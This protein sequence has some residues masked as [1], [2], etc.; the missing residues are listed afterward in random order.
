MLVIYDHH[1][2]LIVLVTTSGGLAP[3][4]CQVPIKASLSCSSSAGQGRE[5]YSERL[6]GWDKNR[7]S[8][9][10][11]YRHRQ[12]GP[13]VKKS[14]SFTANQISLRKWEIEPNLKNSV[15]HPF[16]LPEL[17]FTPFTQ[18]LPAPQWL[19]GTLFL[20]L[21]TAARDF[22]SCRRRGEVGLF[23]HSDL[24]SPQTGVTNTENFWW[25][26]CSRGTA[27]VKVKESNIERENTFKKHFYRSPSFG[28][29]MDLYYRLYTELSEITSVNVILN[30][31]TC[32]GE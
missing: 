14:V 19:W 13:N 31:Q 8:S 11:D 25:L 32:P 3:A 29:P 24:C 17:N 22:S 9:L 20:L 5:K 23:D 30:A 10:T 1:F 4:G 15:P 21:S 27:F 28:K 12:N 16:L 26:S 2:K 7:E 18:L 6:V